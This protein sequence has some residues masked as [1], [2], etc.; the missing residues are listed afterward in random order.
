[1]IDRQLIHKRLQHNP[2][3]VWNNGMWLHWVEFKLLD[4]FA[5]R[6][7]KVF[8][9]TS[10]SSIPPRDFGC[11]YMLVQG[12]AMM[13]LSGLGGMADFCCIYMLVQDQAMMPQPGLMPPFSLNH[14]HSFSILT[15]GWIPLIVSVAIHFGKCGYKLQPCIV[16]SVAMINGM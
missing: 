12:P 7:T 8:E 11:I 15:I 14:Y 2:D 13:P 16:V 5:V 9:N 3:G 4:M 1:M 10:I 6:S